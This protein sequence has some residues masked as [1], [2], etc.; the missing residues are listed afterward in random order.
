[1]DI[2]VSYSLFFCSHTFLHLFVSRIGTDVSLSAMGPGSDLFL[3]HFTNDE[4]G[5]LLASIF[6]VEKEQKEMTE[7]LREKYKKGELF[8]CDSSRRMDH[9]EDFKENVKFPDGN[10]LSPGYCVEQYTNFSSML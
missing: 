7:L 4:I 8:I 10:L 5:R 6:Q 9:F 1:M 2:R 3:G